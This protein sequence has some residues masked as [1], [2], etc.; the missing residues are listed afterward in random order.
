MGPIEIAI[1]I[2][3][4]TIGGAGMWLTL[5]RDLIGIVIGLA[6][7]GTATNL[8]LFAAGRLASS[9][10]PLVPEGAST[11]SAAAAN[12]LPQALV[13]TAIVIGFAIAC[14]AIALV[15]ALARQARPGDPVDADQ[16]RHAEPL[17]RADGEPERVA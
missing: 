13:L 8:F 11:I 5:G 14:F 4:A 15:L 12:P 3:V 9:I 7:I 1:T 16:L 6:L 10:P 17:P 2:A